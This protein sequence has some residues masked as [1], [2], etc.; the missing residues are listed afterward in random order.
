[1]MASSEAW[2]A[3]EVSP[4]WVGEVPLRD[5]MMGAHCKCPSHLTDFCIQPGSKTEGKSMEDA[6]TAQYAALTYASCNG[7]L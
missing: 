6:H 7:C 1:M 3:C 2:L 5:L 4:F